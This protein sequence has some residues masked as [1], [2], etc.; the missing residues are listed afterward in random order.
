M[1]PTNDA[2]SALAQR[3][4]S[5]LADAENMLR[6]VNVLELGA[7]GKAHYS[8]ARD[9]IRMANDNL[10]IRNYVYA[11]QLANK[12]LTVAGLLTRG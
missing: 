7:Q 10:R 3:V 9:F 5:R 2:P 8:Q 6:R 12:A 1:Q 11:E 4:R